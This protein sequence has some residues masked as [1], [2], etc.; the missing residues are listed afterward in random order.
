MPRLTRW[1]LK[2]AL[3]YLLAALLVGLVQAIRPLLAEGTL[4]FV[5]QA[6]PARIHLFVVGWLTLLIFGVVYWMFPKYTQSNPR[7]P[8]WL[9][10]ASYVLLNMGLL[11]RV[12]FEGA[13]GFGWLLV[14]SAALQWLAALAFC[15]TTWPR[16]REK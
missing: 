10:W 13:A 9:G 5:G 6:E 14:L 11:L 16:I 2:T 7:G 8:A 4:A 3:I 1:M 15:L 12:F